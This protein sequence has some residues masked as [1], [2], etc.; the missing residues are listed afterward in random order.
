MELLPKGFMR[1]VPHV[2]GAKEYLTCVEGHVRLSVAGSRYDLGPGDV[3][4]FPGD[5]AHA[6]HN[7]GRTTAVALS[8][9]ALAA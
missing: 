9:V 4:A 1:G 7:P 6:Y 5:Q 8:V 2:R 3:L